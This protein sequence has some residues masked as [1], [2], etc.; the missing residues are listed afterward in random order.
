[1]FTSLQKSRSSRINKILSSWIAL[2]FLC[3]MILPPG[4]ASAQTVQGIFN[5]PTPGS[6]IPLSAA[7]LPCI[8]QGVTVYYDNPFQFDFIIDTGNDDLKSKDQIKN[9]S[10]K[11]IK[12]FLASLTI[13]EED[14]WVNLSPHEENN[15][16]ADSFSKTEMGRDMLAQDYIL[17][18][19]SSSLIYPEEQLGSEFWDA[20][21][22]K[23]QEKYG[24]TQIPLNTFNKVWI[25]PEKAVVFESAVEP[26]EENPS[27]GR[28]AFVVESRLKVMMEE[29]YLA[30]THNLENAELGTDQVREENVAEISSLTSEIYREIILPE[31]EKEVNQGKTFANLRQIFNSM[32][33]AIWYKQNLKESILGQVYANQNKINGVDIEDKQAKQKIYDQYVAALHQGV[34]NYIKEDYDQY[35]QQPI[36]RK[37]FSGGL[38][39]AEWAKENL[40]TIDDLKDPGHIETIERQGWAKKFKLAVTLAGIN[41][42]DLSAE[43]ADV[44]VSDINEL[45][46]ETVDALLQLARDPNVEWIDYHDINKDILNEQRN[47]NEFSKEFREEVKKIE[48]F[49]Q[50][51]DDA[52]RSDIAKIIRDELDSLLEGKNGRGIDYIRVSDPGALAQ[53]LGI[54]VDALFQGHVSDQYGIHLFNV[55]ALIHEL[56]ADLGF[57]DIENIAFETIIHTS[58][59]VL[60]RTD[61]AYIVSQSNNIF[62]DFEAE[63]AGYELDKIP[64]LPE[65]WESITKKIVENFPNGQRKANLLREMGNERDIAKTEMA[66]AEL[67]KGIDKVM[68]LLNLK[69]YKR[70]MTTLKMSTNPTS[71][72]NQ[73]ATLADKSADEVLEILQDIEFFA[74]VV[75]LYRMRNPK[76]AL[77][78]EDFKDRGADVTITNKGYDHKGAAAALGHEEHELFQYLENKRE[79]AGD[80]PFVFRDDMFDFVA[81]FLNLTGKENAKS[82]GY[83]D[84]KGVVDDINRNFFG[85]AI[86]LHDIKYILTSGIGA[87]EM[88]SHQLA[89]F[90]NALF[91][92]VGSGTKWIVVNNPD[93]MDMIPEDANNDNTIIFEMSRSGRTQETF[94]FFQRTKD[95]FKKRVVAA[96][97]NQLREAG[98]ALAK[99]GDAVVDSVTQIPGYIGGRQMNRKTLMVAAPLYMALAIGYN[100]VGKAEGMLREYFKA[101]YDA[102][103]ELDYKNKSESTAVNIAEL[104]LAQREVGRNRLGFMFSSS[105][106]GLANEA[107]QLWNEGAQKY[108][109]GGVANNNLVYEYNLDK[110]GDVERY[111]AAI[112]SN[113]NQQLAIFL[114]DKSSSDYEK[115]KA[116]AEGLK[117]KGIPVIIFSVDLQ[118]D[119]AERNLQVI[120]RT[121]ALMQDIVVYFTYLTN[122]DANSNPAVKLVRELTNLARAHISKVKG[123]AGAE[124][125]DIRMTIE[126]FAQ[127]IG[128]K[129]SQ[130]LAAAKEALAEKGDVQGELREELRPITEALIALSQEVDVAEDVVTGAFIQAVTKSV[131]QIDVGEAANTN[132]ANIKAAF[133]EAADINE[134][135]GQES[136]ERE[137]TQV[138]KQVKLVDERERRVS[139]GLETEETFER[140]QD[141]LVEDLTQYLIDSISKKGE[142]LDN[143]VLTFMERDQDNKT[144]E[145]IAARMTKAAGKLGLS[146]PTFYLPGRAHSG[147][148]G[149]MARADRAFN[150]SVVYTEADKTDNGKVEIGDGITVNDATYMY[151]ISNVIRMFLGGSRGIIFEIKNDEDLAFVQQTLDAVMAKLEAASTELAAQIKGKREAV[152]GIDFNPGLFSL[153]VR[154]DDKGAPLPLPQQPIYNL[155]FDGFTPVIIDIVP[156]TNLPLMLLGESSEKIDI[157]EFSS[158]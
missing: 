69:D 121:S 79:N 43:L 71:F 108:V 33:L 77:K 13:P 66:P 80:V 90:L 15:I 67:A 59:T 45:Q 105:L 92:S 35:A 16:I 154:R 87:N 54:K 49:A 36:P 122:Q 57:T 143:L 9:E 97:Q 85:S 6:M 11:L 31:I 62:Y 113:P 133:G 148:E 70:F 132:T 153:E 5:L 103:Q 24:T 109:A 29:D 124:G 126:D 137:I 156:I 23:A 117:K 131:L 86:D 107:Y 88:Y 39:F 73:L 20:A 151:G 68:Q 119:E 52:G 64:T 149:L 139:I 94:D 140:A 55:K 120:A 84:L 4:I 101:L 38:N 22:A 27:H 118:K 61:L 125:V 128:E 129:Q 98:E 115:Q 112:E 144:I 127:A 99:D 41:P 116:D 47:H 110:K 130:D 21:Y 91:A 138:V 12:Y 63:K 46:D 26:T 48:A 142:D 150:I 51:L 14:L 75:Y 96:V 42:Q 155:E 18:Q 81:E 17:K 56:G 53:A 147:I 152:G 37:Y 146:V 145:D 100:D 104:I 76:T 134:A 95:R 74:P 25:V 58:A 135:L 106:K 78:S 32:L 60:P 158:L 19:L 93:H 111:Q 8:M 72:V 3:T 65:A 2:S 7:H 89:K 141:D 136:P 123:G 83:P 50:K 28:T 30:L 44:G 157:K 82:T 102:N 1:M 114:L 34:F 40:Q 10:R